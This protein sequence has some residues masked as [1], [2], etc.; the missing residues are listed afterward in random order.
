M[1]FGG[2]GAATNV[3][4]LPAKTVDSRVGQARKQAAELIQERAKKEP[5]E[6]D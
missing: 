1:L 6:K 2:G 3:F 4:V 5:E